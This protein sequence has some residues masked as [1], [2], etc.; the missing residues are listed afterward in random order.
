MFAESQS[1]SVHFSARLHSQWMLLFK[2]LNAVLIHQSIQ[3]TEAFAEVQK[4]LNRIE[5]SLVP[6][7]LGPRL[8]LLIETIQNAGVDIAEIHSEVM[9]KYDE[10]L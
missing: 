2:Q 10:G 3:A 7:Q 4:L 1:G 6:K 8:K 9:F 5:T